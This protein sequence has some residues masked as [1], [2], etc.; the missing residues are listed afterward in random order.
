MT[1][2]A[3]SVWRTRIIAAR[4]ALD[5]ERR[6]REDA[7]LASAVTS[8]APAGSIVCAYVP[9]GTEPGSLSLLDALVDAGVE[10]L[11]PVTTPGNALSWARYTGADTLIAAGYGLREPTGGVLE[12]EAVTGAHAVLVPALA[13]DIRG[14]RLGRGAGFYDRTLHLASPDAALIAVVRDDELVDLLPEDPHDIR[15]GWALTPGKGLVRL[16]SADRA[17]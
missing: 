12:P 4:R 9:V 13:V 2:P 7:A 17:K 8:L 15:M 3:K 16:G 11:V 6:T 10:V 1:T 5:D 14:V